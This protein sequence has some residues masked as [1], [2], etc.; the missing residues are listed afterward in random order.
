MLLFIVG[1]LGITI[2]SVFVAGSTGQMLGQF[3]KRLKYALVSLLADSCNMY[4]YSVLFSVFCWYSAGL[5]TRFSFCSAAGFFI[6]SVSDLPLSHVG[7][8]C[9]WVKHWLLHSVF[10]ITIVLLDSSELSSLVYFVILGSIG[11]MGILLGVCIVVRHS[12]FFCSIRVTF[13]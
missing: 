4:C 6:S 1:Q 13:V 10:S 5:I 3:N 11:G 2:P 8:M 7:L 12:L 9:N